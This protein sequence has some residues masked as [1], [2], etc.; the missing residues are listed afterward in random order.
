[1]VFSDPSGKSGLIE[2]CT[3]LLGVD[4]NAYPIAERTRNINERFR[5]IWSI[6]FQAYGGWKFVDNNVANTTTGVPYADQNIVSGTGLYSLP[7]EALTVNGVEMKPAA[8]STF[9]VLQPI[10]EEQF[11]ELGGD[12]RWSTDSVPYY[13]MLFGDVIRLLPSPNFSLASS[14]RVY[15]DQGISTFSVTDTTKTPGFDPT[16]HRALSVGAALDY[17]QA[18]DLTNKV[19]YLQ[20]L[21]NWY[22][23]DQLNGVPGAIEKFYV[24]RF[25]ARMPNRISS[26]IDLVD[27]YS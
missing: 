25:R 5:M 10:T 7:S 14:L 26:S 22:A 2:D 15:F 19:T 13:Y 18:R 23:G 16:F 3:F 24:G 6:I 17:A 1:M 4:L 21:W 27:E 12:G 11:L 8:G 9:Q 20:N